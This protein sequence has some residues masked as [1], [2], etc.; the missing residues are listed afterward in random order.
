MAVYDWLKGK[1]AKKES[2][3]IHKLGACL[4]AVAFLSGVFS[5]LSSTVV[6]GDPFNKDATFVFLILL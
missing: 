6:A 4:V 5:L 1:A 3:P 2:L